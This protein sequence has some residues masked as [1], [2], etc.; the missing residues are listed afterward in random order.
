[1]GR[2]K[3][4]NTIWMKF[5]RMVD[6]HDILTCAYFDDDR[7]R[8]LGLA[9]GQILPFPLTLIVVLTTLSHYTV[10]VCETTD[11]SFMLSKTSAI[12]RWVHPVHDAKYRWIGYRRFSTNIL[13]CYISELVQD[14]DIVSLLW[15]ANSMRCIFQ[16]PWRTPNYP[17][18]PHFGSNG[19]L[20]WV[21]RY[22]SSLMCRC[23]LTHAWPT[24]IRWT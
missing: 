4:P 3:T 18:P 2:N 9:G 20:F 22:G 10:R 14:R 13:L 1:M 6:V 8:D 23:M 11:S 17:K 7:V 16:W 15:K 21:D 19:S 24:I 12:F 5:C